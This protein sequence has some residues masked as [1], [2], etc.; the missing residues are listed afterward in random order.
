MQGVKG[1]REKLS[2]IEFFGM[3]GTGKTTVAGLVAREMHKQNLPIEFNADRIGDELGSSRR[4]IL[5]LGMILRELPSTW[6][7]VPIVLANVVARSMGTK[8]KAKATYNLLTLLSWHARARRLGRVLLLD[9]GMAQALWSLKVFSKCSEDG[10]LPDALLPARKDDWQ[11]IVLSADTGVLRQRLSD[12]ASKHSRLQQS[13]WRDDDRL[14]AAGERQIDEIAARLRR[15]NPDIIINACQ[16]DDM[17]PEDTA[18]IISDEFMR[19]L[20]KLMRQPDF[21]KTISNRSQ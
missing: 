7:L 19:Q 13:K 15:N 2:V 17:A 18:R 14:W 10:D 5:R 12:R 3:P 9:Q 11:L 8:A 21:S 20:S 1:V 16:T 6:L 4:N